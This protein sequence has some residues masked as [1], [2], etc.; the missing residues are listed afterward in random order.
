[1]SFL[2]NQTITLATI[3]RQI[4]QVE[5]S[6]FFL[7][8]YFPCGTD[9]WFSNETLSSHFFSSAH[10]VMWFPSIPSY[11]LHSLTML[12]TRNQNNKRW[13]IKE[14]WIDGFYSSFTKEFYTKCILSKNCLCNDRDSYTPRISRDL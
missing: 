11:L 7:R 3:W 13:F 8:V 12:S 4:L 2:S 6:R 10:R 1:M 5:H 14:T 9:M